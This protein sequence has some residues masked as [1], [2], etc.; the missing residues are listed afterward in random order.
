MARRR[1]PPYVLEDPNTHELLKSIAFGSYNPACDDHFEKPRPCPNEVY[2]I[3]DQYAVMD[4]R[5]AARPLQ[6]NNGRFRFEFAVQGTSRDQ[7]VGISDLVNTVIQIQVYPFCIAAPLLVDVDRN[8]FPSAMTLAP[9]TGAVDPRQSDPV[10]GLN[11]QLAHCARVTLFIQELGRQCHQDV[12][13]RRHHFEFTASV[14]GTVGEPGT[15]MMLT[16]VNDIFTF[17]EP[18]QDIHGLTM[19]FLTPDEEL[20]LPPDE[21][22]GVSFAT[23]AFG[24]IEV[25]VPDRLPDGGAIDMTT[26]VLPGDRIY[27]DNVSFDVS[28]FPSARALSD[29]LTSSDGLFVGNG[30]TA[31]TFT[32]D[33]NVTPTGIGVNTSLP[34]STTP[35]L[36]IA[37]NR[38]RAPFRFRRIVDRLT[39]Y[40]AP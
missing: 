13:G 23:N 40:I 10:E 21:I 12:E 7:V 32:L 17:T 22:R 24:F 34:S 39:N 15:R 35:A 11:S 5:L 4:S 31:T 20:R 36:R 19:Q 30:P 16:P 1:A 38:M 14:V 26:L 6:V 2:G 28:V 27:F 33:P 8:P 3:S 37:K 18:I 29:Y 25:T 9:N